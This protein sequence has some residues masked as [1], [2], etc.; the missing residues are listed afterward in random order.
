MLMFLFDF[1]FVSTLPLFSWVVEEPSS[2]YV[3]AVVGECL[4]VKITSYTI[5]N[6]WFKQFLVLISVHPRLSLFEKTPTKPQPKWNFLYVHK[7]LFCSSWNFMD[8][9]LCLAQTSCE[10]WGVSKLLTQHGTTTYCATPPLVL[11]CAF[12]SN[13]LQ[14]VEQ[15]LSWH[16]GA[17]NRHWIDLH[18]ALPLCGFRGVFG[19]SWDQV[20][21]FSW[22]ENF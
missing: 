18:S 3:V 19:W 4:G 5:V 21:L 6:I 13:F 16:F 12:D 9:L 20:T 10:I 8:H 1:A 11:L 15:F 17:V 14:I 2:S 7:V 22:L